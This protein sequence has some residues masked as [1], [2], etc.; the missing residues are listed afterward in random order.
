MN[1]AIERLLTLRVKDMMRRDVLV[2]R[3]T[4]TMEQA[5]ATLSEAGVSGAPVVDEAGRCVGIVS[6]ADFVRQQ[7]TRNGTA[8]MSAENGG[9]YQLQPCHDQL[10]ADHMTPVVQTVDPESPIINA[11][12]VLC[13]ERIH[14]L[15]VVDEN[16]RPEGVLSSLDFVAAMV[17]AIEE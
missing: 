10:V 1:S 7:S 5:A 13:E 2:V 12:R 4:D 15:V 9:V 3:K 14:R 6:G 17:A 16:G 11:A 8:T